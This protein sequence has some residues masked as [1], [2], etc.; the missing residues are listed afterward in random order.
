MNMNIDSIPR[1]NLAQLPTPVQELDRLTKELNGPKL[2]V[3]RDDQTGLA[4]GGNK[5]RKLELLIADALK[6]GADT[7]I[8]VGAVQSNHCRQTAAAAA[9]VGLNCELVLAGTKPKIPNGNVLI[10][11][12]CGANLHWTTR[13][14][15][16]MKMEQVTEQSREIGRNPYLIPLGGSNGLG[17]LAYAQTMLELNGMSIIFFSPQVREVLRPVSYWVLDYRVLMEKLLESVSIKNHFR[18][19]LIKTSWRK[20]LTRRRKL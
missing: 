9:K 12:F 1:C 20:L 11:L 15:I 13:D 16:D 18:H 3:K 4:F 8:T 7:V 19:R 17:A 6:K 5:T 14:K 10:N 2:L